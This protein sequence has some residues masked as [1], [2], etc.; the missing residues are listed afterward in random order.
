[1]SDPYPSSFLPVTVAVLMG[2]ES[3][4]FGSPKAHLP[5]HGG[6]LAAHLLG[7]AATFSDDVFAV[8]RE[9]AQLP[10]DALGFTLVKDEWEE[11]GPLSGLQ[12]SLS[13]ARHGGLFLTA[14]DMPFLERGVVAGLLDLWNV[15][16]RPDAV[17]PRVEDRWEP[18]CALWARSTLAHL[19][20]G[21]WRSFQTLLAEG[22]LKVRAVT[23]EELR[24][25]DPDL[26]S[27]KNFNT[28]EEWKTATQD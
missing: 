12:A 14:V 2:G 6:S 7:I 1:M 9:G 23:S 4:R 17:V 5:F 18:L 25:W 21:K 10:P 13:K 8:A 11:R 15:S 16:G 27:L 22:P 26:D 28:P 20:P 19:R 24:A 3:S